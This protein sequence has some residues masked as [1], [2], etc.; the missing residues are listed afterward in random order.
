MIGG[1]AF[2][3]EDFNFSA[4]KKSKWLQKHRTEVVLSESEHNC[5]FLQR[6]IA[7]SGIMKYMNITRTPVKLDFRVF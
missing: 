1:S 5:S 3:D 7:V 6:D 4:S 2:F